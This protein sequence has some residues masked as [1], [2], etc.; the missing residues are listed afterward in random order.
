LVAADV[1]RDSY[2]D[3]DFEPAGRLLNRA[4]HLEAAPR[5]RSRR[6]PSRFGRRGFHR[7]WPAGWARIQDDGSLVMARDVTP[8]YGNW[9]EVALTG[10]KN[11]KLSVNAKVEVKAGA[12]YEKTTYAGVPLVFRLGAH[13]SVDTV[14]ITWPNG[15]IQNEMKRP[16]NRLLTVKEALSPRRS[17]PMIFTWNGEQFQFIT[18]VLGV[19]APG[20]QFG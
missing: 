16:V 3:L 7:Q 15:L 19:A 13:A 1:N 8:A 6:V 9:M 11:A 10:V 20:R 17:C 14:R 4:G 5:A 2:T 18:D 12:S